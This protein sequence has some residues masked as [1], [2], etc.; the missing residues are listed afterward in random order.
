MGG[1]L[2]YMCTGEHWRMVMMYILHTDND[3]LL[4]TLHVALATSHLAPLIFGRA[5]VGMIQ[6]L[7]ERICLD[8]RDALM[9][10]VQKAMH[11]ALPQHLKEVALALWMAAFLKNV[12][13]RTWAGHC[14]SVL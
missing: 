7:L 5:K 12:R 14:Y 11:A 6:H 1:R 3:D 8:H 10:G 9:A 4:S 2:A 13:L